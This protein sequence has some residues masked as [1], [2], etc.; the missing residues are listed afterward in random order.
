M[1]WLIPNFQSISIHVPLAG[2]VLTL[3]DPA[4]APEGI[5]IHVPLAGNVLWFEETGE[6]KPGISIHVPLAG[7]VVLGDPST[8]IL[9]GDFYPRSPCGE[10]RVGDRYDVSGQRFLSTFPLR[11][12][13]GLETASDEA[14]GLISIH[15][16]LAGNV[17]MRPC[18]PT[19][20]EYF[21]PRS[22]CGERR[23]TVY[24]AICDERFLSTFPLRGT[25][26][27][28]LN[29]TVPITDFYPRS[30]CG[31]RRPLSSILI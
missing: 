21:Y 14:S 12:T 20:Q 1:S 30:P 13:S 17:A 8:P 7:N 4:L 6:D 25:S 9:T 31:E 2:N 29:V 5:S 15:V 23:R 16:P 22:P 28:S 18:P 3:G 10:R 27:D 24:F 26:Q 19:A 11:G